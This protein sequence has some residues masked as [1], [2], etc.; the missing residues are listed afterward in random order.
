MQSAI[1]RSPRGLAGASSLR[2]CTRRCSAATP[3]FVVAKTSRWATPF[4]GFPR[5]S[6]HQGS[7]LGLQL[8][9]S[10]PRAGTRGRRVPEGR[11]DISPAF[12]RRENAHPAHKVPEGRSS[13]VQSS[14]RDSQRRGILHPSD[15]SL[16]YF[17][18]V[19][20]AR[21]RLSRRAAAHSSYRIVGNSKLLGAGRARRVGS[22]AR[23]FA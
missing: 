3:C 12:Q 21:I 9:T 8:P 15:E 2:G 18:A 11:T 10:G 4:T 16:G 22:S 19:P 23:S 6:G 13:A 7:P 20:P 14:L 5:A 1:R 17:R